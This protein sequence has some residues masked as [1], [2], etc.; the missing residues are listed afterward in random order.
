M[1]QI[2]KVLSGVKIVSNTKKK[3]KIKENVSDDQNLWHEHLSKI[4]QIHY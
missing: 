3:K 1:I 2:P 4:L